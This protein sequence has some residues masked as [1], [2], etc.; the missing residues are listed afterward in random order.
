MRGI[1]VLLLAVALSVPVPAA[2]TTL[3]P[4][5]GLSGSLGRYSL[6]DVNRSLEAQNQGA[7]A[8]L[9]PIDNGPAWGAGAGLDLWGGLSIGAGYERWY[10]S[11]GVKTATRRYD[12]QLPA[13][14]L[15]AVAEYALPT[16]G[17]L[18]AHLGVAAGSVSTSGSRLIGVASQDVSAKASLFEPYFGADWWGQ[19]RCGVYATLGYR[20]AKATEVKIGG[21]V[22]RNPDGSQLR[23]DYS[24]LVF[25]IG[26]KVPL[27]G[28][29]ARTEPPAAEVKP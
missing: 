25:R 13:N 24:G 1:P 23:L 16:R 11:S 27:G 20:T 3:R 6:D 12:L 7:N 15:R 19:R 5:V 29:K 9:W 21:V 4:W 17:A 14:V 8:T 28:Q 22:A 10:A 2:A 18:G 26:L